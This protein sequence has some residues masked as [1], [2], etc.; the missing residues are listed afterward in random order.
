MK[1]RAPRKKKKKAKK[2]KAAN[3]ALIMARTAM[4]TAQSYAQ[5]AIISSV[6]VESVAIKALRVASIVIDAAKGIQLSL[7]D[8][9]HWTYFVPNYRIA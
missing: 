2:L 7:Q 1:L 3:D 6:P 4:I 5:L 8:I 9:K